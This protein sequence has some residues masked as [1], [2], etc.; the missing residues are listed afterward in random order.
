MFSV[1]IVDADFYV[2]KPIDGLDILFSKFRE[3]NV[4]RVP[5]LRIFGSTPGGQKTCVHIHQ[6]FPYL[7]IPYDGTKPTDKYLK[8]FTTSVDFA[9]QVAFGRTS[10]SMKYVHKTEIVKKIPFYGYHENEEEF[11][12]MELYNPRIIPKLVDLLQNGAILN[13]SFQPH[14]AHVPY[15]LQIKIFHIIINQFHFMVH[16]QIHFSIFLHLNTGMKTLF[17]EIYAWILL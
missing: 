15:I 11:I 7:Y 17:L 2:G 8:Q 6:V 12:K 16:L 14:E 3:A 1:R 13:K 10:S 9:V 4:N 5:V